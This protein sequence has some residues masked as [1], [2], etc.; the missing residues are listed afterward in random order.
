MKILDAAAMREVDRTA[1]EEMGIPSLVLMENAAMGLAD[2]IGEAYPDV[3]AVAIFCGPGN[4]GGDGLALARHLTARGYEVE[5]LVV[6]G[7]RGLRGDAEVQ[8]QICRKAGLAIHE[9]QGEESIFAAVDLVSGAD[10]VVDAVFG[11]GLTRPLEGMFARLVEAINMLPIPCVAVDLPS[12]LNGSSHGVMGPHVQADL[13]VTFGAPKVPHVLLPAAGSVGQVVVADLGIPP[14]LI[15]EAAGDLHLL[16]EE[17]LSGYLAPRPA[18]S[19]KGDFGHALIVAGS[20]GKSGAAILA[21]RAAVR[22]GAG[23]VTVAAPEP[24]VQTVELGSLESMTLPLAVG[25]GG[26]LDPRTVDEIL[27][28]SRDKRALAV[29]PGLGIHDST[30][31]AVRAI[32]AGCDLPLVLDADGLNA[33]EGAIDDLSAA[34][35]TRVL[36]PHPGEL[37]RMVGQSVSEIQADRVLSV[38]DAARRSGAVVVLKGAQTLVASPS[39]GVYINATGNP[40]M[41]SGGTGDVLTGILVGLLA[42]GLDA[43]SAACLSVWVHGAAGDGAL[44]GRGTLALTAG[45]VLTALPAALQELQ[46]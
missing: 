32:V 24:I 34:A 4:N 25:D 21:A 31:A 22:S 19:H 33:F 1:I 28:F 30:A 27:D 3:A 18:A 14:G 39:G 11:T 16:T 9:D 40:G 23:L 12:G 37:A 29:G 42:Q 20:V 15:A 43:M 35:C 7:G 10:L 44:E 38:R 13:T 45:D 5:I 36:T 6:T 46:G 41:A 26:G 2:S 17:D 8:L